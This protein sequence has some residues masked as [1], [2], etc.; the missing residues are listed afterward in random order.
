[1]TLLDDPAA[2]RVAPPTRAAWVPVCALEALT[3]ERGVAAL[4]GG[5]AI[6]LFRLG[7]E[8]RAID[9]LDPY[10]GASVLA[11][12][13]VGRLER[14]DRPVRYVAS[15]LRKQRFDL[16]TGHDLDGDRHRA[17]WP[18]RIVDGVVEVRAEASPPGN[19]A[20]TAA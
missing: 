2:T 13:L 6:A 18:A 16:D 15:P 10:A 12:G 4:V 11:R 3:P 19:D 1:M 14:D 5:R 9:N 20:E 17:T 8:V 7:D